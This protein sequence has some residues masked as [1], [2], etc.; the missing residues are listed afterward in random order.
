VAIICL[1]VF[2]S[3]RRVSRREGMVF[4]TAYLAY[5]GSLLLWRI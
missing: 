2:K 3:D 5:L 4:V 1:P